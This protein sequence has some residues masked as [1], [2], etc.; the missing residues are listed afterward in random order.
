VGQI[1]GGYLVQAEKLTIAELDQWR[2]DYPEAFT[3]K[4]DPAAGLR[5]DAWLVDGE[6][7][8]Q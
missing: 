7:L 5:V 4:Y 8:Q 6:E 1:A 2:R 3:R